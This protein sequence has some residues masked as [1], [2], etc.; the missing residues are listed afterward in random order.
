MVSRVRGQ[1]TYQ[2]VRT[3]G[4]HSLLFPREEQD[5]LYGLRKSRHCAQNVLRSARGI[6]AHSRP[7]ALV[8]QS[9]AMT[10]SQS[11]AIDC[12]HQHSFRVRSA[13]TDRTISPEE[14]ALVRSF[15]SSARRR[16]QTRRCASTW[17][18]PSCAHS[19]KIG[20]TA[21]VLTSSTGCTS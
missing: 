19:D 17:T 20:F 4:R 2:A 14:V 8:T 16:S 3:A 18:S 12:L 9:G 1:V 10:H 5:L 21:S 6:V 7:G 15:K 13:T 11:W